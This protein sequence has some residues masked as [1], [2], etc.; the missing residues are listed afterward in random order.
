MF[1]DIWYIKNPAP[2]SAI[3]PN[4]PIPLTTDPSPPS[5]PPRIPPPMFKAPPRT[6][7][8]IPTAPEIKEPPKLNIL[9]ITLKIFETIPD[10]SEAAN[11]APENS[12][13]N[14]LSP[15]PAGEEEPA[16]APGLGFLVPIPK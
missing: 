12:L 14:T 4:I 11:P 9:P 16:P 3:I 6:L 5:N 2:A 15:P 1:F 10:A 8:I 7:P 13:P